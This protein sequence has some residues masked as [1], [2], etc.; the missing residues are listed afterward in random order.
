MAAKAT[1]SH[2][3]LTAEKE[4]AVFVCSVESITMSSEADS[5]CLNNETLGFFNAYLFQT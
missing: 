4:K 1:K 2:Y 3:I 5:V